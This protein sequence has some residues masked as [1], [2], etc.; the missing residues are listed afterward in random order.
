MSEAGA[1]CR[2]AAERTAPRGAGLPTAALAGRPR[3]GQRAL[4]AALLARGHPEQALVLSAP[5]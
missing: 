1:G 4:E 5:A 2:P 3:G